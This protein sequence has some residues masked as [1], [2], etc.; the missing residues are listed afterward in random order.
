M[1][2]KTRKAKEQHRKE[3]RD[4]TEIETWLHKNQE[5]PTQTRR[6]RAQENE[7]QA[8]TRR[9]TRNDDP[10]RKQR[11][12]KPLTERDFKRIPF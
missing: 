5:Q 9:V 11:E 3:T 7:R 6:K 2:T 10:N 1:G 12:P 4:W 8:R